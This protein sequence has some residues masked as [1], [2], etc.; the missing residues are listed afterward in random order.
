MSCLSLAIEC[1]NISSRKI[2]VT[3]QVVGIQ[4]VSD[5]QKLN[6]ILFSSSRS[7]C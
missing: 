4:W 1:N 3:K 6:F 2:S 5:M 7:A